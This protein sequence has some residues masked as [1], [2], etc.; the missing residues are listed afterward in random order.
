MCSKKSAGFA[1]GCAE[2]NCA[3]IG[4]ETQMPALQKGEYDVSGT[5]VGV[6][7]KSRML[8]GRGIKPATP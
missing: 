6:V 8:D 7:E 4:G 2:N 5:I 1:Q 3:L